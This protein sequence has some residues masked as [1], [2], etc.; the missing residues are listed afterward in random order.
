[1]GWNLDDGLIEVYFNTALAD[2]GQP[3]IVMEYDISP[4]YGFDKLM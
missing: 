1:M 2:N 3:C 4:R